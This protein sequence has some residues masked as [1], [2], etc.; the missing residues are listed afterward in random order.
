M[1]ALCSSL[2]FII[3][4]PF[5]KLRMPYSGHAGINPGFNGCNFLGEQIFAN[6]RNNSSAPLLLKPTEEDGIH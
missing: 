5:T 3:S 1:L 4:C 2:L 6:G